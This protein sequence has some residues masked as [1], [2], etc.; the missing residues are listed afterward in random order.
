M[1]SETFRRR[2]TVK[3]YD[4]EFIAAIVIQDGA[5]AILCTGHVVSKKG[6]KTPAFDIYV[7]CNPLIGFIFRI[8]CVISMDRNDGHRKNEHIKFYWFYARQINNISSDTA[9]FARLGWQHMHISGLERLIRV[10]KTL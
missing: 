10:C 2:C 4:I 7:M 3:V 5:I 6:N 1:K 8:R 9:Q